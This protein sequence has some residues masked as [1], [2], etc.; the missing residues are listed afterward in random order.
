MPINI[1]ER[2][3]SFRKDL[4]LEQP[5]DNKN[6]T[7]LPSDTKNVVFGEYNP[8]QETPNCL[9]L[10]QSVQGDRYIDKYGGEW[11]YNPIRVIPQFYKGA[12][13]TF[14][15]G[16]VEPTPGSSYHGATSNV[17][18]MVQ[19]VEVT[20]GSWSNGDAAGTLY[21]ED[22]GAG[23]LVDSEI[24]HD[25]GNVDC[26]TIVEAPYF[27]INTNNFALSDLSV[28]D[29]LTGETS[30]STW[31]VISIKQGSYGITENTS[32]SITSIIIKSTN[33]TVLTNDEHL[34]I[35][36]GT[37]YIVYTKNT[38]R[39]ESDILEIYGT[40]LLYMLEIET[41]ATYPQK[42]SIYHVATGKNFKILFRAGD[43]IYVTTVDD[44]YK[45]ILTSITLT[46]GDIYDLEYGIG[47]DTIQ[48]KNVVPS[49]QSL[50][51]D[52]TISFQMNY[53]LSH[54]LFSRYSANKLG[55]TLSFPGSAVVFELKDYDY[56]QIESFY[57]DLGSDLTAEEKHL[58]IFSV[59]DSLDWNINWIDIADGKISNLDGDVKTKCLINPNSTTKY[60]FLKV[61]NNGF[62]ANPTNH[63]ISISDLSYTNTQI[64][65]NTEYDLDTSYSTGEPNEAW[66]L[67]RDRSYFNHYNLLP[68]DNDVYVL[69]NPYRNITLMDDGNIISL[70]FKGYYYVDVL[71]NIG[72]FYLDSGN[73]VQSPTYNNDELSI[74]GNTLDLTKPNGFKLLDISGKMPYNVGAVTYWYRGTLQG[75]GLIYVDSAK[76][77]TIQINKPNANGT[78][79]HLVGG[80]IDVNYVGAFIPGSQ[81]K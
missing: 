59:S 48:L 57:S 46:D 71:V 72:D 36:G 51:L 25:I 33:Q 37:D 6:I 3:N 32:Y 74:R 75:S 11:I 12:R 1:Q 64:D 15:S 29:T 41:P 77:L 58:F 39:Y 18:F 30:T 31:E 21:F 43:T 49:P 19:S 56:T 40:N 7:L 14:N 80:Y 78:H 61:T 47:P 55:V 8:K 65:D 76:T 16:S 73:Y 22:I 62:F 34:L 68:D 63:Q 44:N 24:I 60:R 50:T 42:D 13:F 45:D 38:Y 23:F 66:E 79:T 70:P 9:T 27:V 69:T 53:L 2:P 28:G 26:M 20:S 52:P 17:T 10:G 67:V 4:L 5:F 81:T 54:H 35:N